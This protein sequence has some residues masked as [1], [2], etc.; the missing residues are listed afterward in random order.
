MCCLLWRG[1]GKHLIMLAG[2][3]EPEQTRPLVQLREDLRL[4]VHLS[5]DQV[6][7]LLSQ[8]PSIDAMLAHEVHG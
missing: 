3:A 2:W 7:A 5:Q 4:G 6:E 8:P 1:D